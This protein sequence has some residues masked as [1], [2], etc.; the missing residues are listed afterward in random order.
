MSGHAGR[1]SQRQLSPLTWRK[2]KL[3]AA[4]DGE[5]SMTIS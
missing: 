2:Q 5:H 1:E 4:V 3:I